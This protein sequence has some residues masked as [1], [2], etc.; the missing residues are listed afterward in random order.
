[1]AIISLTTAT[2]RISGNNLDPENIT[3]TL[4]GFPTLSRRKG[5][6]IRSKNGHERIAAFGQWHISVPKMEPGNLD[7]Q[8]NE[9][10]DGL[11]SNIDDWILVANNYKVDM[12]CGLFMGQEMEGITL[13]P[14]TLYKLGQRRITLDLDIYGLGELE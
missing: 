7:F 1:M 10:L 6:V 4:G 5:D 13:E 8:V 9:I 11:S 2:L 12:F 14:D 3:N